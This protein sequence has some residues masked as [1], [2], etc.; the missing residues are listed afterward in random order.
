MGIEE[1]QSCRGCFQDV[2][3]FA[4]THVMCKSKTFFLKSQTRDLLILSCQDN[5]SVDAHCECRMP[6]TNQSTIIAAL[7]VRPHESSGLRRRARANPRTHASTSTLLTTANFHICNYCT[8]YASPTRCTTKL[9][10]K[11]TQL[12]LDC[13]CPCLTLT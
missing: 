5:K 8:A 13:T 12:P 11:L 9:T 3:P 7:S 4:L 6:C 1:P 10:P 2:Q